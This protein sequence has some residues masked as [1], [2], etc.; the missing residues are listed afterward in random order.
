MIADAHDIHCDCKAPFAHL[1]DNIFPEGHTDRNKSVSY[2]IERDLKQCLSGGDGDESHG[3]ELGESAATFA[4][5]EIK[6]EN[7]THAEE[8]ELEKLL[9][10]VE[11]EPTR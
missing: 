8:E 11:E 7:L 5:E 10:A 3:I 4:G 2:I 1:L 6:E 9:A